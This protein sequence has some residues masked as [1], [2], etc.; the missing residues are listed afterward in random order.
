M[1][2]GAATVLDGV[3]LEDSI[4]VN[5]TCLTVTKFDDSHFTVG[6]VQETLQKDLAGGARAG[7]AGQSGAGG[8]AD[9]PDSLWI[10]VKTTKEILKY[11]VP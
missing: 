9:E 5:G 2:I 4:A 10:K 1:K 8:A 7:F 11:V 3:H 6:L